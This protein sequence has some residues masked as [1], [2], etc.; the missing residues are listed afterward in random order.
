MKKLEKLFQLIRTINQ[1]VL[2]I[3]RLKKKKG[4]KKSWKKRIKN[5]KLN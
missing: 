4:W 5:M 1:E 2:L 3:L